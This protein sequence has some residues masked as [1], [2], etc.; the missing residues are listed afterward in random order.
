VAAAN[1]I[2]PLAA[3]RDL[4]SDPGQVVSDLFAKDSIDVLVAVFG[5]LLFLPLVAPRYVF[6]AIPALVLGLSGEHAVKRAA[7]AGATLD[8]ASPDRVVVALAFVFIAAVMALHRM[9]RRSVTRVNV[10]H[11]LVA[12]LIIA[13]LALFAQD[14]ASSP[15]ER[16][17]TWGAR[18]PVD[19]ARVEAAEVVGRRS[20]AAS[21]QVLALVAERRHVRSLPI[22]PLPAGTDIGRGVDAVV[23]DTTD[24]SQG[25]VWNEAAR[26]GMRTELRKEGFRLVYS[27]LGVYAWVR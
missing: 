19:Q 14:A 2:A 21:P 27:Q 22:Q 8:V 11:R 23:V 25:G 4:F 7:G 17:W 9:G 6:P 5:G 10:D 12:A 13:A 1:G 20:V 15:Y 18:T 26:R 16:P 3:L 24:K